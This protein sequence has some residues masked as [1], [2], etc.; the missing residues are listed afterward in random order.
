[1]AGLPEYYFLVIHHVESLR[2]VDGGDAGLQVKRMYHAAVHG[3]DAYVLC[4][5]AADIERSLLG[6]EQEAAFCLVDAL[7]LVA[8]AALAAMRL[9]VKQCAGAREG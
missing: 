5:L 6:V 7:R 8:A 4:C 1:M 9:R 3:V 2:E